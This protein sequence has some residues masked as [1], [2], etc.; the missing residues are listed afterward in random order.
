MSL[1]VELEGLCHAQLNLLAH[2]SACLEQL[3]CRF[4]IGPLLT[5]C[6]L[7]VIQKLHERSGT[8]S[9]R[10]DLHL[11]SDQINLAQVE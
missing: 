10:V 3:F 8:H 9:L 6:V 5:V 2:H 11:G 1:L 7:E 4:E